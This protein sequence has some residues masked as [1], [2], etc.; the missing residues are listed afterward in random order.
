MES[1]IKKRKSIRLKDYDYSDDGC[2]FITICTNN[3]AK[4]LSRIVKENKLSVGVA[5]QGDPKIEL[6]REGKIIK[7]HIEN[8]NKQKDDIQIIQYV[9]MPD[10][11]HFIL[12]IDKKGSPWSATPTV[13]KII[14]S[15]KSIVSKEIGK[16]IWQRNYYEHIIRNE[17]ELEEIIQYIE[18]NPISNEEDY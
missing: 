5:L 8:I 15:F 11:I 1:N 7:K 12:S 4:F 13:P 18:Y 10:H 6:Y 9:I 16:P 2:Y 14:N 17:K 3:R